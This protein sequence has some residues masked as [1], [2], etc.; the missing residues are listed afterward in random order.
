MKKILKNITRKY[1]YDIIRYRPDKMGRYP[2]YDMAKFIKIDKPMIFDIGAN[3][4]Q[5]IENFRNVFPKAHI[6]SFEPSPATFE[7]LKNNVSKMENVKIWNYGIGANNGLM[8]LF[9]NSHSTMSSFLKLGES[10]WGKVIRKTNIQVISID[11]FCIDQNI[12]K[13][14]I[15]KS[16]TQGFE[17]EIFKG[18]E[19]MMKENKIG[20]LYFE[21][22]FSEMYDDLPKLGDIYNFLNERGFSLASIYPLAYQKSNLAGWTDLLFVNEN[23]LN[24]K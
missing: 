9:E 2:Y 10:G 3:I 6:N 7:L 20:V 8:T 23:F 16:D 5:T 4:G 13:I 1:G 14:D 15:I 21:V 12:D 22:T 11:Q 24:Q 19:K 17:L 18:A